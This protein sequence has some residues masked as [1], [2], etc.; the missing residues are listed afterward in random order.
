MQMSGID[1]V[2]L[3][4]GYGTLPR[5]SL[6]ASFETSKCGFLPKLA[7]ELSRQ[8]ATAL[9]GQL[10]PFVAARFGTLFNAGTVPNLSA[11]CPVQSLAL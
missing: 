7:D 10:V 4:N 2:V 1:L 6:T 3:Q 8:V 9:I 11:T 5:H